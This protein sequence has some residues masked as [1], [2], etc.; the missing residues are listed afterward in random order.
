MNRPKRKKK[1]TFLIITLIIIAILIVITVDSSRRLVT[2]EYDVYSERLPESFEGFR[3]VQ[4]SDLHG[5]IYGEDNEK[6]LNA[7]R[8]AEPDIIAI[9]GDLFDEFTEDGYAETVCSQLMEIAPVYYCS[10]N[11]EWTENPRDTFDKMTET[12]TVVMRNKYVTLERNGETIV[13]AGVDDPNGPY[14]MITKEAFVAKIKAETD[15][16]I[17][18][19]SHRNTDFDLWTALDVDLVLT[20]HAHG[21]IIRLPFIGGVL[22]H[23]EDLGKKHIEGTFEEDGTTMV[24]SRGAGSNG[25]VPRFNNNPEIVVVE[26][27]AK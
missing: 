1:K 5:K 2:T 14:D 3:I 6:L 27:H 19:L 7:V 23:K 10:G 24:V 16:Y 20:G 21:G 25:F 12:G 11:H 18:M 22:I 8:E 17:L 9:T 4:L 13:L 26:L 15:D